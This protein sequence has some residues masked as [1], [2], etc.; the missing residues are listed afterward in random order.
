MTRIREI[1][2][3]M[4]LASI[5]TSIYKLWYR[6]S[7]PRSATKFSSRSVKNIDG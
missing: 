3:W 5:V 6:G 1:L 4:F 7:I 2:S